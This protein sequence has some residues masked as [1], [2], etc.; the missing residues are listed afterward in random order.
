M[1]PRTSPLPSL[2]RART[3]LPH[4]RQ[5]LRVARP[6]RALPLA[7]QVGGEGRGVLL[8]LRLP[9]PQPLR[10]CLLYTSDAADE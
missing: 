3:R 5:L 9:Q 2:R 4:A 8:V 10:V 1:R 6:R 7:L